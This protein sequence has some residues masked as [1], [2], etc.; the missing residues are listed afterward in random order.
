MRKWLLIL[1]FNCVCCTVQAQVSIITTICGNDTGAYNGDSILAK[2]AHVNVPEGLCLDSSGNI[3][4]ADGFSHRI[5]RID[6]KTLVIST[7]AGN[8]NQG[9]SGDGGQ[10]T[11]AEL[12]VP[13][14]IFIDNDD[15]IYIADAGNNRIRKVDGQTKIITTIAGSGATGIGAG[16]DGGDGGLSTNAQLN[17]P[18]C[19]CTDKSGNI[20]IADYSNNKIKRVDVASGIITT[21]AGNGTVVNTGNGIPATNT[22]ISGPIQVFTDTA[23][24]LIF[25]D[26][27]NHL[28]RRVDKVTGLVT[29][30]A[31]NGTDGYSG[32]NGMATN[33][34]L[35]QPLGLF[36]DSANNIFIVTYYYGT[37]RKV[38]GATGIITT[39]AG[40]GMRGFSGDGG[41][42]TS[43]QTRA[44][45]VWIDRYGSMFIADMDNN[46]IRMVYDTT[47]HV[48]VKEV[49]KSTI[50]IFP[51]PA[52]N[53]LTIE[54]AEG[55]DV[56]IYNTIGQSFHKLRVI[57]NKEVID[58]RSLVPGMYIIQIVGP[59]G[60]Q[61]VR[62][63]V[64]EP[65]GA[66]R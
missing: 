17:A 52:T 32:D 4:I 36:V 38:N 40:T 39:V 59:G 2:Y 41:P 55:S 21:V 22:G 64:K 9:F 46:R 57:K 65:I 45:D 33:A 10:A 35:N 29:T 49:I 18:V 43:A 60:E 62:R 7:V 14:D 15:N 16:G 20:Y 25:S 24:N 5:R 27:Y 6:I 63:F 37:I 28:V 48:G 30:V 58:V 19:V 54:G 51:N 26:Q 47:L 44:A 61:V 23:D 3:Y 34:Q 53:E 12:F 13:E 8:G 11:N 42:P 1:L 56:S 66:S 50:K 31:G